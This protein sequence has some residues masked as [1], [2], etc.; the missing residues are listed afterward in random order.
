MDWVG[1]CHNSRGSRRESAGGFYQWDIDKVT[2]VGADGK[3]T[4]F[5]HCMSYA[6]T[7]VTAATALGFVGSR[8]L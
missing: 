1:A 2:Q 6:E 8:H 4:V 3:C 7:L 5:G